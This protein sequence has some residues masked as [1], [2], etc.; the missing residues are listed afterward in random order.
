MEALAHKKQPV[1]R[2]IGSLI[3]IVAVMGRSTLYAQAPTPVRRPRQ[4]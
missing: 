2:M 4:S 3:F 1:R